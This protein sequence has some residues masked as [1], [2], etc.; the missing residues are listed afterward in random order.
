MVELLDRFTGTCLP[1]RNII[2]WTAGAPGVCKAKGS[3]ENLIADA[4]GVHA[5]SFIQCRLLQ[6][7]RNLQWVKNL[8]GS[9]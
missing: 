8:V 7:R 4:E 2:S 3:D 9:L 5:D 6:Y 1:A